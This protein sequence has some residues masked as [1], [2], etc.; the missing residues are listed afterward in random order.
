MPSQN[1]LQHSPGYSLLPW[2]MHSS[3]TH[4]P[5]DMHDQAL[6]KGCQASCRTPHPPPPNKHQGWTL[7][8]RAY[9]ARG[10]GPDSGAV[11]ETQGE[12]SNAPSSQH[13]TQTCDCYCLQD[14]DS[15]RPSLRFNPP[16]FWGPA[17]L[18]PL[19]HLSE[20]SWHFPHCRRL[21]G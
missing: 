19:P 6:A 17:L 10:K 8:T 5:V 7:L 14:R 20:V 15:A 21:Q 9:M 11:F 3:Q 16:V 1:H 18:P 4:P 2:V 12:V 13:I